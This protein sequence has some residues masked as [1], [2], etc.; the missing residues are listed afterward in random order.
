[1]LV[2]RSAALQ[3]VETVALAVARLQRPMLSR[4]PLAV[5]EALLL[6]R[7]EQLP[8]YQ[9]TLTL[10]L[11]VDRAQVLDQAVVALAGP[12]SIQEPELLAALTLA[13]VAV[14]ALRLATAV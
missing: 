1:M 10:E 4:F 7:L 14:A 11:L 5:W 2:V 12:F 6:E 3:T 13:A 8:P 9:A